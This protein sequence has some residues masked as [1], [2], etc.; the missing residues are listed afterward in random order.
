MSIG[1]PEQYRKKEFLSELKGDSVGALT[2][3]AL[4]DFVEAINK[5]IQEEKDKQG[6]G[7]CGTEKPK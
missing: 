5:A 3:N 4:A 1:D 7:Q 2:N 6:K